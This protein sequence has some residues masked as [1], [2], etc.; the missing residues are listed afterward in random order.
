LDTLGTNLKVNAKTTAQSSAVDQSGPFSVITVTAVIPDSGYEYDDNDGDDNTRAFMVNK[1]PSGYITVYTLIEPVVPESQLPGCWSLT[2]GI[3]S[4]QLSRT[5][6]TAVPGKHVVKADCCGIEKTTTIYV[7]ACEFGAYAD[8]TGVGHA[9]WKL[10]VSVSDGTSDPF[11]QD[12]QKLYPI[13]AR[14]WACQE[15][16]YRSSTGGPIAPGLVSSDSGHEVTASHTWEITADNHQEA[17]SF[18]ADL[19]ANPGTY[20]IIT[21]N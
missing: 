13:M 10:G 8:C 16:G 7:V 5:V 12:L 17:A 19:S 2:G 20:N 3:G 15:A 11:P 4:G 6:R 18:V 9:W 1:S 14:G 21:N